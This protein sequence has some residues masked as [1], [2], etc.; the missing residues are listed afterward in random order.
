MSPKQPYAIFGFA[1]LTVCFLSLY[2][3][4][5][6][7]GRT[8]PM[9]ERLISFFGVFQEQVFFVG[10]GVK[11]VGDHYLW[12]VNAKKQNESLAKEVDSL[13]S[14]VANLQEVELENMR[15]RFALEFRHTLAQKVIAAS[16]VAHDV[17]SDFFSIRVDKGS[18]DGVESGMGVVSPSGVVG[19]VLRVSKT[20]S[21]IATL[22]D[23][24]SK[25][26]VVIQRSRA[27]GILTGQA[28]QLKC[29]LRYLDR[30]E[31]VQVDDVVVASGFGGIFPEGL[32]VGY[33]T[34]VI[35]NPTSI[36]QGV[37]VK[38]AVDVYRLEEV[39]IVAPP[40]ES[41]KTT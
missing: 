34:A 38:S 22:V 10:K 31:D 23:P 13:R 39:F 35:P 6:R 36:L 16:V 20:Y 11:A 33:V 27:R 1:T 30:L 17:S 19:R 7:E 37:T 28:K 12:L 40:R 41:K 14:K 32:L 18:E 9:D 15:L 25:I 29:E 8:R 26:D 3:Y 21:D 2:I 5:H 4:L 24:S